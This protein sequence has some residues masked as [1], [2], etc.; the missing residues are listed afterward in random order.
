V[1]AGKGTIDA[2]LA[3]G[4]TLTGRIDK[5]ALTLDS[6]SAWKVTG[7]STLTT[8]TDDGGISGRQV[9][10]IIGN[11]H[12]VTYD[13][14]LSANGALGAKTYKLAGGGELKPA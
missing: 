9:K 6:S 12:T 14:S 4:T 5:A 3:K 1:T 13:S 7:N 11:G 8:L 10:N 2:T